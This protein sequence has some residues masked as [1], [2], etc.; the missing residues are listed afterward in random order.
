MSVRG[1]EGEGTICL[2]IPTRGA[3]MGE[4][5]GVSGDDAAFSLLLAF[6][7]EWGDHL[8]SQVS[9]LAQ[10]VARIPNVC[11]GP[12]APQPSAETHT[13]SV[14][15]SPW[16]SIRPS[17]PVSQSALVLEAAFPLALRYPRRPVRVQA[18]QGKAREAWSGAISSAWY[19]Q[20]A[21]GPELRCLLCAEPGSE[22][23]QQARLPLCCPI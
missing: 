4:A 20:P 17:V 6:G 22:G 23:L 9:D 2:A 14:R 15:V 3:G 19:W 12:L 21:V 13:L 7:W 8:C 1:V 18:N 10:R 11:P 5:C 16:G